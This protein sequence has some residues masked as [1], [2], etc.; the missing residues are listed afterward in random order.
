LP[1]GVAVGSGGGRY[2]IVATYPMEHAFAVTRTSATKG[3]GT[4]RINLPDG[5]IAAYATKHATN[6][7]V[8]YPGVDVQVEVY[9]PSA[10][11]TPKLVASGQIVPVR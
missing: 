11:L 8:A 1:K 3:K 5:G 10:K 4:V 2:L 6:I 7:Y 9:D